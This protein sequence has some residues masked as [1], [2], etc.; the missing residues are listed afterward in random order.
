MLKW[1]ARIIKLHCA[2]FS[3]GR[4]YEVL[5]EANGGLGRSM[6]VKEH[7]LYVRVTVIARFSMGVCVMVGN[8]AREG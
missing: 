6:I 7:G 2:A 5:L 1:V 4:L 3:L 8:D